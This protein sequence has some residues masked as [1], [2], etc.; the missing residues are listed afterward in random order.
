MKTFLFSRILV[1]VA[2]LA[3]LIGACVP[4][5]NPGQPD[6]QVQPTYT[7]YVTDLP[8][9]TYTPVVTTEPVEPSG[10]RFSYEGVSFEIDPAVASGA[11]GQVIPENPGTQD[12]PYWLVN[13]PY[14]SISLDGYPLDEVTFNP[15]IAVYPV[16]DYRRLSTLAAENLDELA[17]L[18]AEKP[19]AVD[20]IPLIPMINAVQIMRSNVEYLEFQGGSGVR[21]LTQY[22][23][24]PAPINNEEVFY[25]FQGLTA[26]GR[27]LISAI[28]PVNHP[29]LPMSADDLTVEE[30]E[31][32][33]Q[34]ASSYHGMVTADLSA[35]SDGSFIPDL[36]KL[37]AMI[38]SLAVRK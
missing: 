29:S 23:Q 12:G 36:G 37:D 5:T 30:L 27:Y 34:N 7:P 8:D 13:P 2:T 16:E 24:Y 11:F 38:E 35:Q 19:A 4:N 1:G 3:L 18:L 21:F 6:E 26:D 22:A 17:N 9:P 31:K 10:S 14:V 25:A 28:L 33:A 15:I 20:Q 32:I